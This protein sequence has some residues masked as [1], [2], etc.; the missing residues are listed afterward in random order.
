[1]KISVIMKSIRNKDIKVNGKRT[2]ASYKLIE[3]DVLRLYIQINNIKR[4]DEGIVP[5]NMLELNIVY[6]DENILL[7]DKPVG[8]L[9]HGA[10]AGTGKQS[11]SD[12][13]INR[14]KAYLGYNDSF[15]FEPALCNRIDR[16][17]GGIVIAAKTAEALRIMNE[18]IKQGE[19]KRYY[20]CILTGVPAH[21]KATLTAYHE[22]D[23]K[24]NTVRVSNRK[25]PRNKTMITKYQIL[26]SRNGLSLAEVELITGRTHQI[27]AHMAF[28]GHPLLGDGK[29]GSNRVN[30]LHGF[31][32]QALYSHRTVF[33]F[34]GERIDVRAGE[35]WFMGKWGELGE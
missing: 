30:K 7:L 35:I 32:K 10:D 27:R 4:D 6:E 29:Y 25:T 14:V 20:L 17:T 26:E 3:G 33:E 8:L 31:D 28:I 24:T 16:N 18:K 11:D 13:L 1:M 9:C 2:E 21:K 19:V 23:S 15:T 22:K 12:T 34:M 5:C